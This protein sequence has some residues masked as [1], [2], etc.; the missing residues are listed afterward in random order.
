[1]GAHM[2][3]SI[4]LLPLFGAVSAGL[5]GRY[6]GSKGASIR[7]TLGLMVTFCRSCIAF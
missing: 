2:Y 3:L 5:F 6:I 7:T 4:V 1:M